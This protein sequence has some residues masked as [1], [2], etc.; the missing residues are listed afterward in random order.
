M[1]AATP[2]Q[3]VAGLIKERML[4]SAVHPEMEMRPVLLFPEVCILSTRALPTSL[5]FDQAPYMILYHIVNII[6]I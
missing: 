2:T 3:G 6:S 4:L 5:A 1:Q